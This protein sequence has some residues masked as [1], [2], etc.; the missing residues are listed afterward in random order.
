[1]ALPGFTAEASIGPF[2]QMY[3][4]QNYYGVALTDY[5]SPQQFEAESDLDIT[6]DAEGIQESI[7]SGDEVVDVDEEV[8]LDEETGDETDFSVEM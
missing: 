1:M 5:L 4:V 8:N 6:N 3:R 7:E 2:A